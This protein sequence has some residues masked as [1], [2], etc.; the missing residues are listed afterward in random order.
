MTEQQEE[1]EEQKEEEEEEQQEE[2]QYSQYSMYWF[3]RNKVG[4]YMANITV[5]LIVLFLL[6]NVIM[7]IKVTAEYFALKAVWIFM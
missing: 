3:P 5:V 7:K 4:L 6:I 1:E 2:Q